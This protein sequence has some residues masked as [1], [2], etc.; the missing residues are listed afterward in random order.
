MSSTLSLATKPRFL[1]SHPLSSN[2]PTPIEPTPEP[3][4]SHGSLAEYSDGTD[5]SSSSDGEYYTGSGPPPTSASASTGH[6][7]Q[8]ARSYAQ[9]IQQDDES[10][11]KG[12]GL[13]EEEEDPFADPDD[14]DDDGQYSVNTPGITARREWK[15]V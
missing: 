1:T 8:S 6:N 10:S 2:L 14:D 3:S 15:E 13:L 7:P 4:M 5:Y 9:Y 12:T 11:G